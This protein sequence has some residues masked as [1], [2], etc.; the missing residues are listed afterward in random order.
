MASDLPE[1]QR[2]VKE[3]V[4]DRRGFWSSL[5]DELLFLQPSYVERYSELSAHP[6]ET[7]DRK[8]KEL[9][10]V[11][12]DCNTTHLYHRGTRV[13]VNNAFDHGATIDELVEVV[14][15]TSTVG[16]H[17]AARGAALLDEVRGSEA[18]VD[19]ERKAEI[20]STLGFWTDSLD[21]LVRR[22]VEHAEHYANLLS[23]AWEEGPLSPKAKHLVLLA[24]EIAP[25]RRN[26]EAAK[27]HVAAA[28]DAG[29]TEAE[30]MAAIETA[31]VIGVHSV[32][33]APMIVEEAA[34]RG[35]VPDD[36]AAHHEHVTFRDPRY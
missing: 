9:L 29:A 34:R 19:Q 12:V 15:L 16:L 24:T 10:H 6:G 33:T 36:L 18:T 26:H 30:V 11:A 25:T 23:V 32:D 28:L 7:L 14:V 4:L 1:A 8:L 17:D 21:A 22:D 3:R 31:C 2:R 5:F 27:A 20:E 35:Q 13:H